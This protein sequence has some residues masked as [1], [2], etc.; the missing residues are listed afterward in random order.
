[1]KIIDVKTYVVHAHHDN[2]VITKIYT[3]EGITGIGES[4][5]EGREGAV[6]EAISTL[7]NYLIGKDPFDIEKHYYTMF[8][9]AYWGAGAILTGALSAV[10]GA[11]WD[12]KGKAL[13][14]PVYQ[15]LGGKFRD[16]IRVYANRWFFGANTAEELAERAAATVAKGFTALKWD[17]FG[18]A[19]WTI[20]RSQMK[21]VIHSIRLVREAVG[22]EVDILIEGHGRF[23]INTAIQISKQIAEFQPMFFEEPIM[24]ENID[25]L[26]EVR[27]KSAVPIAAGERF[28]TKYD[29]RQALEK[30]AVDFIQPDL[31]V[32]GGI[33]EVKKIAAMAEAFFIPVAPHNIHGQVGTAMSLQI[34][35]SIPNAVILEFNVEH[36]EWENKL[37]SY[38]F[39]PKNGY[40]EIPDRVG[41]GIDMDEDIANQYPYKEISMI[42]DMFE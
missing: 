24:P 14:V 13:N 19:E 20:S 40:L 27:S 38:T 33:A 8:R 10:D 6:K 4:S 30:R 32:A 23:D 41:L 26:A 5:V 35:A 18:K 37:F 22:D 28:Y 42:Q 25:G 15:L 12:I 29:F 11:L 3:D 36:I 16:K 17:P 21:E 34:I 2:W 1:M 39:K 31:R 7:R 9:D